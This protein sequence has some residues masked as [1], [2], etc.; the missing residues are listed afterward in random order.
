MTT[1]A[2]RNTI[3]TYIK[4]RYWPYFW[5]KPDDRRLIFERTN[6]KMSDEGGSYN[7]LPFAHGKLVYCL[8]DQSFEES[9]VNITKGDKFSD[10]K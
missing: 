2:Q 4:K 3:Q 7:G 8:Y 5:S 1:G 10:T 9:I 6:K